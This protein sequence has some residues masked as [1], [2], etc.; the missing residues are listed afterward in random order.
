MSAQP[1]SASQVRVRELCRECS[2]DRL[3]TLVKRQDFSKVAWYAMSRTQLIDWLVEHAPATVFDVKARRAPQ[4]VAKLPCAEASEN[5]PGL[6]YFSWIGQMQRVTDADFWY[7]VPEKQKRQYNKK[8]K[9][10]SF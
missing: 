4:V 3:R 5:G 2:K 6:G 1:P 10:D 8:A 9:T 7:F